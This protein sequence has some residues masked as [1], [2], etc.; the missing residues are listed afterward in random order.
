[1]TM[2]SI[3]YLLVE[4]IDDYN[5]IKRIFKRYFEEQYV[6]AIPLEYAQDSPEELKTFIEIV[7]GSEE[8]DYII[9]GD[10]KQ[11]CGCITNTKIKI[12]DEKF[13]GN[14]D[15]NKILIVI[16][17][18]EG[19]YLAGLSDDDITELKI[20]LNLSNTNYI[21]KKIFN[22]NI[23]RKDL[24]YKSIY[25]SILLAKFKIEYGRKRNESF[26]YC[27]EKIGL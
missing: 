6:K 3:F 16:R 15:L 18:I 20:E 13:G 24:K 23:P 5:F 19:W 25:M 4:G 10:Y 26:C 2:K 7:E 17:E 21:T 14:A 1:M 8:D 27:C 12:N 9:F 11:E 22:D